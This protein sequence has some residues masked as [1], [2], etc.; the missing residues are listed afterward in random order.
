MAGQG[1]ETM[2]EDRRNSFDL[3]RLFAAGCV[4]YGHQLDLTGHKE[5]ELGAMGISIASLGLYIFFGLS[6]YLVFQSLGRNADAARY[7][8]ARALRIYPG[9]IVNALFCVVLGLA[10]T[11]LDAATYLTSAQT[12]S[13][14]AHNIAILIP[15]TQFTLPGVLQEA[16]W[17]VIN[18]SIWTLKY[19]LL[20][21][22]ALFALYRVSLATRL[23]LVLAMALAALA[24]IA[25]YILRQTFYV[26]PEGEAFFGYFSAF[27][28]FR[29]GLTFFAGAFLA[30]VADSSKSTRLLVL[31]VP[32]LLIVFGP[33]PHFARAGVILLLTLFVIELGRSP[34]LYS[35]LYKRIGDLSYGAFLY[36]Y[37]I[38]I[39]L[40]V[41]FYDGTNFWSL[42]VAT[43]GVIL[44][45]ALASW[46][47]IERPALRLKW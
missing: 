3:I 28:A 34:W 22:I 16:R 8:A 25:A 20:C 11:G 15:P 14:L 7:A 17:P 39:V 42:T 38:Q 32:A 5:P 19:E 45:T 26:R 18:G 9:A 35:R 37:P 13:Y 24:L 30:A 4:F 29:F 1:G 41:R 43:A 44:V 47:L 31:T 33:S 12:W 23:P 10:I 36:A 21:Y 2:A 46:R 40:I 27:N 6:G